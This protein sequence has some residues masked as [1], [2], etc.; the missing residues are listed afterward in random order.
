MRSTFGSLVLAGVLV[1][2]P[3]HTDPRR[4]DLDDLSRVVRIADPQFAPD[5]HSIVAVISR[6]NLDEDRWDA[7]LSSI[8][9]GSGVSAPKMLTTGRRGI[10][11]PRFSPD[12]STIA[13]LM[14][15]GSGKDAHLQIFT[16]EKNGSEP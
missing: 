14:M 12:G 15:D 5:G 1:T 10:S 9:I 2:I 13:F 11:H 3:V 6:A 7:E 16:M 8:E 4:F